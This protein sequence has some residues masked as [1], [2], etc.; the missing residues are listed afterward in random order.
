[1]VETR[2]IAS[3]RDGAG[4]FLRVTSTRWDVHVFECRISREMMGAR[5]DESRLY[6][7]R[8]YHA[9]YDAVRV[10]FAMSGTLPW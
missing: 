9:T 10:V 7:V 3:N 5:R 2:F 6:H 1:M 4:G 8:E